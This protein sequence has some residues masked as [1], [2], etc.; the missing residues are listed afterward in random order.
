M[1]MYI[2][3]RGRNPISI[4]IC[5]RC[6]LKY[7]LADLMPD[8]NSPGLLVCEDDLDQFDPYRLPARE[9]EKITVD[10]P[11]PDVSVAV[12]GPTIW[13][14]STGYAQGATTVPVNPDAD[15]TTLPI[16]QF[17]ALNA[18]TSG[19]TAPTWPSKTGVTVVDGSITWICLGIYLM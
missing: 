18:G 2:D 10:N 14:A 15:T 1:P 16:Y 8:P 11:R 13:A 19:A 17:V 9:T 5:A 3:T 4:G 12:S 6:G 7:P